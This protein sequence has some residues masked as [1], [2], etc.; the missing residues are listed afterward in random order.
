[1]V[2]EGVYQLKGKFLR[3]NSYKGTPLFVKE[4]TKMLKKKNH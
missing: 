4:K 3:K 2:K 1:M